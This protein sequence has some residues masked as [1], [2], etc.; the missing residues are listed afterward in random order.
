MDSQLAIARQPILEQPDFRSEVPIFESG[1]H[2]SQREFHARYELMSKSI[3]AELIGGI[4]YMQSSLKRSHGRTHSLLM[5]WLRNYENETPGVECYDNATNILGDESEPQ[6]DAC[7]V[8][9]PDKGG[10]SRITPDDYLEGAPEFI[11]EIASSSESIDLHTKK[12]DYEQAGVKEYLVIALRQKKIIWFINR[13]GRF[14]ELQAQPD[15]FYHSE[16][17]PGLWLDPIAFTA[18]DGRRLL[19]ALQIGLET[20]EHAAFVKRLQ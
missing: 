14:E 2:L 7:L 4:V 5:C 9:V 20:A 18:L 8:I 17:F 11:G 6:P 10:Q 3:K 15:G 16:L 12:R 1:D 19:N 13:S